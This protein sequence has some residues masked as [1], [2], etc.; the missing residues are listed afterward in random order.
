M[1][2]LTRKTICFSKNEN[3]HDNI[4]GMY[5]NSYYFTAGS[6]LKST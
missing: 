6:F 2:R 4:I 3:I 1:K 5:I